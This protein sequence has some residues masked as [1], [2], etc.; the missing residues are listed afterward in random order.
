VAFGRDDADADQI[1]LHQK[2]Q[3]AAH[4]G[5]GLGRVVPGDDDALGVE[6]FG[7]IPRQHDNRGVTLEHGRLDHDGRI[8]GQALAIGFGQDHQIG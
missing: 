6:R 7:R 4:G 2:R 1:G 5:H 3:G 8:G